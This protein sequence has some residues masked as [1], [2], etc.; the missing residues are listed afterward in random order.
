MSEPRYAETMDVWG[1]LW[2]IASDV[3]EGQEPATIHPTDDPGEV[4]LVWPDGSKAG[5]YW[6][7]GDWRYAEALNTCP[8]D[9]AA[10]D[11]F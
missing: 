2:D 6:H 4:L 5:L 9:V 10:R 8:C 11:S 7:E 3:S 1:K